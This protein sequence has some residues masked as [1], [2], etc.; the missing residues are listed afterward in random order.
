M[1]EHKFL[2][3]LSAKKGT[4]GKGELFKDYICAKAGRKTP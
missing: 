2:L 4:T 1:T 3:V